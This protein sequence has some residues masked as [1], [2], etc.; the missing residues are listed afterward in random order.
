MSVGSHLP[1]TLVDGAQEI[2]FVLRRQGFTWKLNIWKMRKIMDPARLHEWRFHHVQMF[3]A[4][5]ADVTDA[6]KKAAERGD[7][8]YEKP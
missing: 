4:K 1:M 3:A 5:A 2:P 8:L 6:L 7:T